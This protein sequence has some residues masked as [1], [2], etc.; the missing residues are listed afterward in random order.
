VICV[1]VLASP[2][3]SFWVLGGVRHIVTDWHQDLNANR[4]SRGASPCETAIDM[5]FDWWASLNMFIDPAGATLS[6]RPHGTV[7]AAAESH[8]RRLIF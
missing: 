7:I 6:S 2:S 1:P 8:E 4:C 3:S 5:S